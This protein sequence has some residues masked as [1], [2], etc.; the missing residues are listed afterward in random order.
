MERVL[1]PG[2]EL[3]IHPPTMAASSLRTVPAMPAAEATMLSREGWRRPRVED[4]LPFAYYLAVGVALALGGYPAHR[5]AILALAVGVPWA[6][7]YASCFSRALRSDPRR[8]LNADPERGAWFAVLWQAHLLVASGLAAA[9]T[10]GAR[11]PLLVAML[12]PYVGAVA[13]A[14]D[15][16]PTRWL[17]VAT[18]AAAGVLVALP[19]AWTGPELSAG[20][21]AALL[22]ASVVG[23]GALLAP[24]HAWIRSRR[25]AFA[26]TYEEMASDAL[27]QAQALEQIGT[28][29]AHELKNPLSGVKA[30]VQLGLRN[31]AEAA[32]HERLEV[33]ER[34]VTRMQEILHNYLSFTRP[35][36][37][38][39]PREVRLG[40]LVAEALVALSP[41]ADTA[42][43]RLYTE[44]DAT[45][46]ADPRRLREALLNLAANAIEAT[47]PGGEVVV[48][49]RPSGDDAE[50]VVR[51]TGR[52]MSAETLRRIGTPFFTTR[53]EGTGLGVVLARSVIVQHGGT[54]R[55]ESAPGQGT[56]VRVTLPRAA[57]GVRDAG[58]PGRR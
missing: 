42:R 9:I 2:P 50:I 41:R 57:A 39:S 55:Y 21:H 6:A 33:V 13:V 35:L 34:E 38:V 45:L 56:S 32:S 24:A 58:C 16:R 51:D 5:T 27:T 43:V 12:A 22:V 8:C 40:Q 18:A 26:R 30:L 17:L 19:R 47:P 37:G 15:R 23:V 48:E 7:F 31:D 53:D 52:G 28:K 46:E 29:V 36:Q 54:L 25:A 14:G 1:A 49:V 44:G 20:T 4:L 3:A 10:G 11:S